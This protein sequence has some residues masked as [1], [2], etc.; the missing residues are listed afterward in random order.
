MVTLIY[1]VLA[2]AMFFLQDTYFF[3]GGVE[4]SLK[5]PCALAILFLAVVNVTEAGD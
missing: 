1:M 2:T 4:F 3:V 5:N